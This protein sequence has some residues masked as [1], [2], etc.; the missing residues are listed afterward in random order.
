MNKIQ[1]LCVMV[2]PQNPTESVGR[3][4]GG[5]GEIQ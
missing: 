3:E 1:E 4:E 5:N 2:P